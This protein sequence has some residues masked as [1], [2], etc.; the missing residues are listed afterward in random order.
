MPNRER[1]QS[2]YFYKF[3]D[4]IGTK[5]SPVQLSS[6]AF[7]LC[8]SGSC[9]IMIDFKYYELNQHAM[10]VAFP[11]SLVQI[12]S[13]AKDFDCLIMGNELDL[14]YDIEIVN[15]SDFYTNIRT[16]PLVLLQ[17]TEAR[18]LLFY[19]ELLVQEHA[20]KS[21]PFRSEIDNSFLRVILYEIASIYSKRAPSTK[22]QSMSRVEVIFYNFIF[23][24]FK[25]FKQHRNL[26]YYAQ[27]QHI[28]P[29]HLSKMVKQASKRS[30]TEWIIEYTILNLKKSLQDMS[31]SIA[32]IG[33]DYNFANSSFFAQYFKKYS[34]MTPREYRSSL[35]F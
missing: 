32:E 12:L 23:E 8:L 9:E 18:K 30:A 26:E 33:D 28:T 17:E 2:F 29:S 27:L 25:S 31:K 4:F 35:N 21:H 16:N 5:H 3:E 1:N 22:E 13:T 19:K 34:G 11:N 20:Q 7:M 6:A 14:F 15:K 10:V 24:L